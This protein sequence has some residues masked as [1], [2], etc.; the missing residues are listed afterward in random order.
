MYDSV[1]ILSF[2]SSIWSGWLA[3]VVVL[4]GTAIGKC[5]KDKLFRGYIEL[6]LQL[7]E[8]D[9]CRKLYEKFLEFS[10]ENCTTWMKVL[11]YDFIFFNFM[12]AY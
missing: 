3:F 11:I 5:P 7:R 8:F 2:N 4:Q 9:R 12:C 6:E 1:H 10:P